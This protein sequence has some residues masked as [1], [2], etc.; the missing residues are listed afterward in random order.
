MEKL[1]CFTISGLTI[2]GNHP[3]VMFVRFLRYI[4]DSIICNQ[5]MWLIILSL[6]YVAIITMV[7]RLGYHL[8][9]SC[10]LS[11]ELCANE[12]Y[13]FDTYSGLNTKTS[14]HILV[15][16]AVTSWSISILVKPN[17]EKI[18]LPHLKVD[19]IKYGVA[20]VFNETATQWWN[21][22]TQ[23][24]DSVYGTLLKDNP[25]WLMELLG[26][27]EN[28]ISQRVVINERILWLHEADTASQPEVMYVAIFTLNTI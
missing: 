3:I 5:S 15:Y 25:Q 4:N 14:V 28:A 7:T 22:F 12:K 26:P 18:D 19:V 13:A 6:C 9:K 8:L 1:K 2:H 21:E 23:S 10:L 17:S 24:F 27:A 11:W 20:G 16:F